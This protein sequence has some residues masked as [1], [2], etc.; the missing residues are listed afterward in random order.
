MADF[1][2][3]HALPTGVAVGDSKAVTTTRDSPSV[4]LGLAGLVL[5]A[6][7]LRLMPVVFV[8]SLNWGDEIF[9]TIEPAHRLVYGYGLVPWEFQLGMRSWLLPGFVA[10]AMELSRA[11][12]DG[13][14]Y[15]LTA[16][17]AAFA[18]L[19][20]APVV[21]CFLWARRCFGLSAGFAAAAAVTLAPELI[22][23]GGRALSEVAA[24]HLLVIGCYLLDPGE[25]APSR[26]RM[27]A[28]GALLGLVFLLRIQLAPAIALIALWSAWNRWR[29]RLPAILAGGLAALALGAMLDWATLGQPLASVWRNLLYNLFYGVNAEFGVEPWNYYIL[30][31]L[32]LWAGGGLVLLVLAA[33]GARRLPGVFAAALAIIAV[34]SCIAH[35]EY[36][37][38]YPA[39]LL[40]TVLA[41]IGVG[42]LIDWGVRRL[43]SRGM[44]E[45]IALGVATALV[46]GYWG[47]TAFTL[48]SGDNFAKLRRLAS[49]NLAAMSF[50]ARLPGICGI[51]LYGLEGKDWVWYGGYSR[52]H[53]PL[54]MYWPKDATD[55]GKAVPAFDT[56]LYTV[57]PPAELGFRTAQ[58]FGGVCVARR[59]GRCGAR[60]M[61]GMPFP[62]RLAGMAPPRESF[63][64]LPR[65]A[66]GVH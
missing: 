30:G 13:P 12:G 33:L 54:P 23:F 19:A 15:Y 25:Y 51:G 20:S 38:I 32:G 21:C 49:D 48:W 17:A 56:L 45:P 27:F 10:G 16:T 34:H 55:L 35:K 41:G 4:L 64:A 58:C 5:L 42:Q 37:F 61:M 43:R 63:E 3:T 7:G 28:A 47:L 60:P 6:V 8:P 22:Y 59:P 9:Q 53:R 2:D 40:L 14:A 31:E 57:A 62:E 52:L 26:R 65:S 24:A 29:T 66:T 50:A 39:L 46:L 1:A 44:R 36:R 11:F 18:L